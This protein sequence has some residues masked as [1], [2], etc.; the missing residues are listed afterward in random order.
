[1]LAPATDSGQTGM[2]DLINAHSVLPLPAVP[3][4]MTPTLCP[5]SLVS[6]FSK[7]AAMKSAQS[8]KVVPYFGTLPTI[9][10]IGP[11]YGMLWKYEFWKPGGTSAEAFSGLPRG[12]SRRVT[13]LLAGIMLLGQNIDHWRFFCLDR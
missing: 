9:L 2:I 4:S 8:S 3:A 1:M 12:A 5:T 7:S 10:M 13:V 11:K 6:F